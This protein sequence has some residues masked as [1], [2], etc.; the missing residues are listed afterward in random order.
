MQHIFDRL[1]LGNA[2][3]KAY[4]PCYLT[5]GGE[6]L[7][8]TVPKHPNVVI[9]ISRHRIKDA[10]EMAFRAPESCLDLQI[11]ECARERYRSSAREQNQL[12]WQ[13]RNAFGFLH[14]LPERR[15][16]LTVPLTGSII[17]EI[18]HDDYKARKPNLGMLAQ[19]QALTIAAVQRR[20]LAAAEPRR[21]SLSFGGY[22]EDAQCDEIMYERIT[23]QSLLATSSAAGFDEAF[24]NLQ[25][26]SDRGELGALVRR[27]K[28]DRLLRSAVVRFLKG[29]ARFTSASGQILALAGRDNV[30]FFPTRTG[31]NYLLIDALPSDPL[32]AFWVFRTVTRKLAHFPYF[33]DEQEKATLKRVVNFLRTTNGISLALGNGPCIKIPGM[34]EK[35]VSAINAALWSTPGT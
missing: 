22:P 16:C 18:F 4:A 25:D 5:Q 3:V 34:T 21:L 1:P 8:Y 15:H 30:V 31:W 26:R 17:T 7:V 29:A 11:W 14:T 6:H 32:P 9:K 27:A 10:L 12:I 24:C 33:I 2:L 23:R 13:L 19:A 35:S 20:T 28:L